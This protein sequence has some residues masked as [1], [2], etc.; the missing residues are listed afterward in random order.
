MELIVHDEPAATG[1][2]RATLDEVA[3]KYGLPAD[4]RFDL[5]LAA[6][7]ALTNAL[8]GGSGKP[9]RVQIIPGP[10]AIEVEIVGQG[11]FDPSRR[12]GA[13]GGRGI[14]LMLA[15]VDA[16]EFSSTG[17]GTRVRVRKRVTRTGEDGDPAF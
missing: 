9:V 14:P 5:K 3:D 15:L 7:E 4:Q 16:V 17:S 1:R 8:R 6:T 10:D 2:V 11:A 12:G 13:E